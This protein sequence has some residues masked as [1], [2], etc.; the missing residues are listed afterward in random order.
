MPT[1]RNIT[2]SVGD[3]LKRELSGLFPESVLIDKKW[4]HVEVVPCPSNGLTAPDRIREGLLTIQAVR[5]RM[6]AQGLMA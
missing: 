6:H 4:L 5:V 2:H 1:P 3:E